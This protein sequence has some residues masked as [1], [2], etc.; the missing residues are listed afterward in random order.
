VLYSLFFKQ[1]IALTK[2]K[3]AERGAIL[4]DPTMTGQANKVE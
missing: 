1:I 3:Y 2:E 4:R